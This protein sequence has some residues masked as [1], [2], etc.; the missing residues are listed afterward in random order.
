MSS[1]QQGPYPAA[2]EEDFTTVASPPSYHKVT[3]LVTKR[4]FGESGQ[5]A[6]ESLLECPWGNI[7]ILLY[8]ISEN[9][10]FKQIRT[11]VLQFYCQLLI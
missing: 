5:E 9:C 10:S 4:L 1:G 6:P 8:K 3:K 2:A 11:F 7:L